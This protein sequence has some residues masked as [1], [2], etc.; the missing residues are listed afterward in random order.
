METRDQAVHSVDKCDEKVECQVTRQLL[1]DC[2]LLPPP[3][4]PSDPI[5]G[6]SGIQAKGGNGELLTPLNKIALLAFD[7][8]STESLRKSPNV[9]HLVGGPDYQDPNIVPPASMDIVGRDITTTADAVMKIVERDAGVLKRMRGGKRARG[10]TEFKD[11]LLQCYGPPYAEL[12]ADAQS[13]VSGGERKNQSFTSIPGK[14]GPAFMCMQA[15]YD[16]WATFKKRTWV[17]KPPTESLLKS[18]MENHVPLVINIFAESNVL[19]SVQVINPSDLTALTYRREDLKRQLDFTLEYF[20]HI[21]GRE[22]IFNVPKQERAII[23]FEIEMLKIRRNQ[24]DLG[25]PNTYKDGV[26]YCCTEDILST[27]NRMGKLRSPPRP[28]F[29]GMPFD[30]AEFV[31]TIINIAR[32]NKDTEPDLFPFLDTMARACVASPSFMTRDRIKSLIEGEFFTPGNVNATAHSLAFYLATVMRELDVMDNLRIMYRLKAIQLEQRTVIQQQQLHDL[33]YYRVTEHDFLQKLYTVFAGIFGR[34]PGIGRAG[35]QY[36]YI[37]LSNEE[38][39]LLD[40][41]LDKLMQVVM[42][43]ER[44]I[45]HLATQRQSA[46]F[47]PNWDACPNRRSWGPENA[48]RFAR[49]QNEAYNRAKDEMQRRAQQSAERERTFR[50]QEEL[51]K[52]ECRKQQEEISRLQLLVLSLRHQLSLRPAAEEQ[53][54]VEEERPLYEVPE[55]DIVLNDVPLSG[56]REA[57]VVELVDKV[58]GEDEGT[59][60]VE[61]NVSEGL[62]SR[63]TEISMGML[64]L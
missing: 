46:G 32:N 45:P 42:F 3:V 53:S 31:V 18:F 64:E 17:A 19:A 38:F 39:N 55:T 51:R 2:V 4:M 63:E 24:R 49:D 16:G 8:F 57:A 50:V 29:E 9:F 60:T 13:I 21:W 37:M 61:G 35:D 10:T 62:E 30:H 47:P 11:R 40:T 1:K 27:L 33:S 26:R 22:Y 5:P 56:E 59:V 43:M 14:V 20:K 52:Y 25:P 58:V 36:V 6:P 54:A 34:L 15:T 28:M 48:G 41:T 23:Q 12:T 7:P 44:T